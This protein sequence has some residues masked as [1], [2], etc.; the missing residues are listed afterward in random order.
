[1]WS[2]I[3]RVILQDMACGLFRSRLSAFA[4]IENC[5]SLGRPIS[6]GLFSVTVWVEC[7]AITRVSCHAGHTSVKLYDSFPCQAVASEAVLNHFR[8]KPCHAFVL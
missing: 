3:V 5:V 4:N 2:V 6:H 1:M 8:F 7:A